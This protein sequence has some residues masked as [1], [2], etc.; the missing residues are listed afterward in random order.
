[1]KP[2]EAQ[3]DARGDSDKEPSASEMNL[4]TQIKARV[5]EDRA[6]HKKAFDRMR[7]DMF[8]A[9]H[10]CDK[11]WPTGHYRANVVGRHIRSK[12]AALYA[13]NPRVVARRAPRMDFAVWDE[14]AGAFQLAMQTVTQAQAIAAQPQAPVVDPTTGFAAPV[15]PPALPPGFA[16]AQQLVADVMQGLARRRDIQRLGKTLETLYD[17]FTRELQPVTFKT[18]LKQMVRRA[19]TTGVGYIEIGFQRE[20]GRSEAH[21]SQIADARARLDHLR[22]LAERQSAGEIDATRGEIFELER[23]LQDLTAQPEIVLREGLVF[24]FPDSTRVIPDRLCKNL[25]GFQGAR[26]LTIEYEYTADRVFEI[27]GVKLPGFSSDAP[28]PAH[29]HSEDDGGDTLLDLRPETDGAP[30]G[31]APVRVWKHY[32]V[33]SGLV[34]FVAENYDKFLKE[35]SSPDVFVESFWP[36]YAL[37]LNETEDEEEL[38]PLS[39]ARLLLHQQAEYNRARQGQREHRRAAR[40]RFVASRGTLDEDAIVKLQGAKPFEVVLVNKDPQA[41][42]GDLLEAVRIPGVDPNLYETGQ[43]MSDMEI[44]AGT[45]EA[46]LGA[47][48]KSTAT[49]SAIAANSAASAD[50]SAIDDLDALLTV[51]ARASGQILLKEMS[52]E[53]VKEI[54]GPGAFWPQ[55]TLAE[56]AGEIY[57]DVEAGSTGKPNRAVEIDNWVKMFPAL[58]QTPGIAPEWLA[59]ETIRRLDDKTDMTEALAAGIPALLAQ[60]RQAQTAPPDPQKD[61][62]NQGE[63]G[64]DKTASPAAQAGTGAAF[65]SN[66]L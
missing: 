26:R 61:P 42:I 33:A 38:F 51:V 17:Y 32:D 47:V 59:K 52:E 37:V 23:S 20:Y 35:P 41:K 44:V 50:G 8:L 2:A 1:M 21:A 19:C 64:G 60:N 62:A 65:G 14:T 66:Q 45:Q 57:L 39:D 31:K 30:G 11:D 49:E 25:V 29:D 4:V 48:S 55:L 6:A 7:E 34:Y 56:I 46:Q 16:E 43:I 63:K 36:V 13:K 5:R 58:S 24:D 9:R 15:Q 54:V 28:A 10:G 53:K 3:V 18:A 12:T 40:P 22:A 27:F